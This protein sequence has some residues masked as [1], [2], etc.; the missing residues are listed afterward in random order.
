MWNVMRRSGALKIGASALAAMVSTIA[1]A[2]PLDDF[3]LAVKAGYAFKA[4]ALRD[5]DLNLLRRF[6]APDAILVGQDQPPLVGINAILASYAEI[7]PDR[8]G[9]DIVSERPTLSPKGDMGFDYVTYTGHRNT[10]GAAPVLE[11]ILLVFRRG[12]G[13]WACVA[14]MDVDG[15][16]I[17]EPS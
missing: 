9:A 5:H 2:G 1:N 14:E 16:F 6:Y 11:T 17:F 3:K 8:T 12:T 13:G 15:H 7:L 10:V 4:Q